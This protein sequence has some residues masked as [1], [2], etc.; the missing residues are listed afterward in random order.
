[1]IAA[2][3]APAPAACAGLDKVFARA[4][5]GAQKLKSSAGSVNLHILPVMTDQ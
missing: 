4:L 2:A 1:M 5:A 3:F